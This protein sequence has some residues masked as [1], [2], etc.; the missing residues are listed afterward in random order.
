MEQG[1]KSEPEARDGRWSEAL[2]VG[3]L[4]FVEKVKSQ[5][6]VKALHREFEQLGGAY[7]QRERSDAYGSKFTRENDVLRLE[8]T[9]F[10]DENAETGDIAWSVRAMN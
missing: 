6:G 10:W 8:N 3:T 4:T 5:L 9:I 7:A 1:L 2:A